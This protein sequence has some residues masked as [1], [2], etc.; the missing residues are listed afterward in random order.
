MPPGQAFHDHEGF[1]TV[2]DIKAFVIM[3]TLQ[4]TRPA[5]PS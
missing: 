5:R 3:E 4:E 1:T 2:F